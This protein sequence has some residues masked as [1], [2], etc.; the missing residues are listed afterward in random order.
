MHN[1]F[2]ASG[3][4]LRTRRIQ[5]SLDAAMGPHKETIKDLSIAL[6]LPLNKE[7]IF[8]LYPA[9]LR[10]SLSLLSRSFSSSLNQSNQISL[11]IPLVLNNSPP[12]E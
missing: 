3:C 11:T 6:G 10:N 12:S 4:D 7:E 5:S 2:G 9:K 8:S 1:H